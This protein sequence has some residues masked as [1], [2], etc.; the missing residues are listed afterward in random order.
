VQLNEAL[1]S[2]LLRQIRPEGGTISCEV[3]TALQILLNQVNNQA[4]NVSTQYQS[5]YLPQPLAAASTPS[6]FGTDVI[7]LPSTAPP[8]RPS[9][10]DHESVDRKPAPTKTGLASKK[11][12]GTSESSTPAD[13]EKKPKAKNVVPKKKKILELTNRPPIALALDSDEDNVS[14]YQCLARKQIELFETTDK[15]IAGKAQGRNTPIIVGQVGVRCRHC[16]SFPR[17]LRSGGS[18]YYSQILSGIYQ[19]SQ[20]MFKTHLLGRCRNIPE[21]VRKDLLALKE[22]TSRHRALAGGKLYWRQSVQ[23]LGVIED[24]HVLRFTPDNPSSKT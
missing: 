2:T 11:R 4:R 8:A 10:P 18:V 17:Q 1:L 19:V 15:D 24:E 16:A 20:N 9:Q 6:S 21:K 7:G 3:P 23:A 12:A 13:E 22:G 5:Q 14:R